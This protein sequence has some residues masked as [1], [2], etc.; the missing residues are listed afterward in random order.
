AIAG[1]LIRLENSRLALEAED[2][3]MH[4]WDVVPD[5]GVIDQIPG[6]EI[7]RSVHDHVPAVGEDPLDVLRRQLLLV[8]L[9]VDVRVEL[10]NRARRRLDLRLAER[11]RRV[12]DLA[13]QVGLVD[14]VGIDDPERADAGRSE[15]ER[16]GR[17]EA[18]R[19]DQEY[20]RLQQL[21]LALF[22]DLGDQQMAAVAGALL[23]PEPPGRDLERIAAALPVVDAAGERDDVLVAELLERPRSERRAVTGRAVGDD[24]S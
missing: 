22:A 20:A 13:L 5:R 4:E 23:G 6:W 12:Q 15:V 9:H 8:R 18:A 7:V 16:G 2:R 19:P 24:R 11:S 21:Q 14:D 3:A 17:A 10:A 1:T